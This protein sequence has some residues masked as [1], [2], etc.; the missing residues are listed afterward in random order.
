MY[1]KNLTLLQAE[2]LLDRV[3]T[4]A[5]VALMGD[6]KELQE[7]IKNLEDH[8]VPWLEPMRNWIQRAK[9]TGEIAKTG[10]LHEKKR[11]ASDIFGSNLTLVGKKAS[12]SA[13]KPWSFLPISRDFLEVVG[14][15]GF[16]PT[17]NGLKGRCST[18][19]LPTQ[20]AGRET[21]GWGT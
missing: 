19:E 4:G 11:L 13:L 8:R 1:E 5:R 20:R 3:A 17:T 9:N 7:E 15:V 2:V 12:G 21:S 6:K 14:R 16:E 18:T 10:S